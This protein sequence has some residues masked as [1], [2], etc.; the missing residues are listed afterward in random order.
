MLSSLVI[1]HWTLKNT[2]IYYNV[3]HTVKHNLKRSKWHPWAK[4]KVFPVL[5]SSSIW[6]N[7]NKAKQDKLQYL[8]CKIYIW[9][10]ISKQ[11]NLPKTLN[12][13]NNS[14]RVCIPLPI[15]GIIKWFIW[16]AFFLPGCFEDSE[17]SKK[18]QD[19]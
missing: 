11:F 3:M 9:L 12:N 16:L 2:Y 14:D 15:V 8:M 7:L 4:K 1:V 18:W 6:V 5:Y 19:V 17:T 13:I 10:L